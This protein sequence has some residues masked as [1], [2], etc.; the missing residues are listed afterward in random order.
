[1]VSQQYWDESY[2]NFDFHIANDEVTEW[3]AKYSGLISL[4]G[5]AFE[6]GC[7][8]G[9]Y[10]SF[11]GKLGWNLNGMDLT[12]AI[13][14]T[15]FREWLQTNGSSVGVLQQ[16]D[17]L[18]YA[19]NTTDRFDLV[20]SFGFIEHFENFLSVLALHDRILQERGW[21]MVTTPNFRGSVQHF[22]HHHLNIE[23]LGIHYLPSMQ[24]KLWRDTLMKK[25]YKVVW[26]GYFGGFDFWCDD[27]DRNI[28]QR[29]ALKLLWK[30]KPALKALPNVSLYSPYCGIIAQ[31]V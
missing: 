6:F 1:M 14:K 27:A 30:L 18:K 7:F 22:L 8:P 4:K 25:G 12:P 24:P 17:V 3:I 21:L 20:C 23:A 31:K 10:L 13:A 2:Q 28:W 11:L 15:E 9:R 16:G 5:T 29:S 19:E 26:S